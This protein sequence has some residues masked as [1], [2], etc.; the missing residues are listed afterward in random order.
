MQR[1][2]ELEKQ[3]PK[4]GI[5]PSSP[6]MLMAPPS[7]FPQMNGHGGY[8]GNMSPMMPGSPFGMGFPSPGM[9]GPSR[10]NIPHP[11]MYPSPMLHP[12]A[13]A[14]LLNAANGNMNMLNGNGNGLH[15][16]NA[17]QYR[18]TSTSDTSNDVFAGPLTPGIPSSSPSPY[19]YE[20]GHGLP[21]G[22]MPR[23]M[24]TSMGG[25]G[26]NNELEA[27]TREERRTSIEASVLR[28]KSGHLVSPS[29]GQEGPEAIEEE[30]EG[31]VVGLG[32][33][34]VVIPE[35]EST[36]EQHQ[37]S[38]TNGPEQEHDGNGNGDESQ[39]DD[40]QSSLSPPQHFGV[41]TS[42]SG[43]NFTSNP[44]TPSPQSRLLTPSQLHN[45]T[46]G[47]EIG[48]SRSASSTYDHENGNGGGL[49]S[50]IYPSESVGISTRQGSP[51]GHLWTSD[52][53]DDQLAQRKHLAL[54]RA[55]SEAKAKAK[56]DKVKATE[57]KVEEKGN[58]EETK[59]DEEE[60]GTETEMKAETE[61]E[62]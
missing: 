35:T 50:D 39:D 31:D 15:L 46:L 4:N 44:P 57:V 56:G 42:G 24:S 43:S 20:L 48:T 30:K 54:M 19:P 26:P 25:P 34:E 12:N 51:V 11:Q 47:E 60:Q 2:A 13:H 8:P 10:G 23:P 62:V 3:I 27:I 7:P 58:E 28:K 41:S 49:H 21:S 9:G 45:V 37:D 40:L 29:D 6:F 5:P 1:V 61:V 16:Q 36:Q 55:A 53:T 59:D 17:P 38:N 22:N 18:R 33:G 14:H 32:M 52:L